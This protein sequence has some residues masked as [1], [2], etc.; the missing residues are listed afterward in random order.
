[1]K[2]LVFGAKGQLGRELTA[3]FGGFAELLPLDLPE[4]DITDAARVDAAVDGFSP[5]LIINAAAYTDVERAE[6]ERAAAFGV[7]VAGAFNAAEAAR[8]TGAALVYYSTDFVFDGRAA[9]PLTEE[10]PVGP[11]SPRS[12]YGFTKWLGEEATRRAPRHCILRTAWLYGPGGNNFVEKILAAARTRPELRVVT[13]ETGCP[14]HTWDLAEATEALCRAGAAGTFHVVNSGACTRHEFA[15]AIVEMAGLET[16]VHPCLSSEFPAA[17][18]RPA[19]AVL[20]TA[21]YAR[22]AGRGMRGWRG[23]LAHYFERRQEQS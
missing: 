2:V 21:K 1:M 14:T 11:A 10:E 7:N 19:Y 15:R 17:A 8:R 4:F 12:V 22:T 23:A 5:D 13:D 6:M 9:A 16:P 3:R 18:K 20:D